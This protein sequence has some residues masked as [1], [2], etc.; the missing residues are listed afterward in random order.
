M[1][2]PEFQHQQHLLGG[3]P[4]PHFPMNPLRPPYSQLEQEFN[5]HPE[6]FTGPADNGFDP[7]HH[8]PPN[9]LQHPFHP[10]A[11]MAARFE[12]VQHQAMQHMVPSNLSAPHPLQPLPGGLPLQ[13]QHGLGPFN[14]HVPPFMSD[15]HSVQGFPFHHRPPNFHAMEVPVPGETSFFACCIEMRFSSMDPCT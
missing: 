7:R 6:R 11:G 14:N 9:V 12:P 3:Q 1:M 2:G 13:H 4:L 5:R 10:N 15:I 8:F